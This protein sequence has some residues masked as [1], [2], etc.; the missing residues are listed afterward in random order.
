[1]HFIFYWSQKS[2]FEAEIFSR[3]VSK[4]G[5]HQIYID[6]VKDFLC[7][8]FIKT[9]GFQLDPLIDFDTRYL[10]FK[11]KIFDFCKKQNVST[12]SNLNAVF[13]RSAIHL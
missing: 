12:W 10:S 7:I 6:F 9:I 1:M 2:L 3:K 13:D 11:K 4:G 8:S 5:F